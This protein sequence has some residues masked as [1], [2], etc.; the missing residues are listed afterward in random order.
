MKALQTL[1]SAMSLL[2]AS[3][4]AG[5]IL[6]L[7]ELAGSQLPVS[8][9]ARVLG[10]TTRIGIFDERN[11]GVPLD[12]HVEVVLSDLG[13]TAQVSVYLELAEVLVFEDTVGV[14]E[15]PITMT[16]TEASWDFAPLTVAAGIPEARPLDDHVASFVGTVEFAGVTLPF[17][18]QSACASCRATIE[19]FPPEDRR[20][21]ILSNVLLP[22]FPWTDIGDVD[23]L[24]FSV[25]MCTTPG[26]ACNHL[27]RVEGAVFAPEPTGPL[28][29]LAGLAAVWA[30]AAS[31]RRRAG[32]WRQRE[33]HADTSQ[34]FL[35]STPLRSP[36][37]A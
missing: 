4:A 1:L 31:R 37:L 20:A 18:L 26:L 34:P 5:E 19:V 23:G 11:E 16:V 12:G 30:C 35:A 6:P 14:F 27:P 3:S 32:G 21:V 29:S 36:H 33:E 7:A 28:W 24:R 25:A 13:L 15:L 17:S 9:D 2:A 8:L 22:L 10:D